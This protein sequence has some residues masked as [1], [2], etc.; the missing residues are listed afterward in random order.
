M[1]SIFFT[2][3]EVTDLESAKRSDTTQFGKYF[4]EMLNRGIY[5]APSQFESL[6]VSSAIDEEMVE[7][8]VEVNFQSLKAIY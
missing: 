8:I 3:Q 4:Q 1:F 7:R 5:L 6:F 2:D